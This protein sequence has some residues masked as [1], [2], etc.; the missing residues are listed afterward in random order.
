MWRMLQ[1]PSQH[2]ACHEHGIH[3]RGEARGAECSRALETEA[4]L[5]PSASQHP[6]QNSASAFQD[7]GPMLKEH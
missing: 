1:R 6:P 4:L 5:T 2:V 3:Q 7:S